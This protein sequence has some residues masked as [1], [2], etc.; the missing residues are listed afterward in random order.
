[1]MN[2]SH[3]A[4]LYQPR[5][6]LFWLMLVLNGLSP[7]L[8]WVVHNRPLNAAAT[9]MVT[10]FAIGNAVLGMW[11]AWRLLQSEPAAAAGAPAED[12]A[13]A[14]SVKS[15]TSTHGNEG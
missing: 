1:M 7:L 15:T 3:L 2:L 13:H 9:V 12:K 5:N 10:C 11:F 14:P 4:R 8:A 6:P